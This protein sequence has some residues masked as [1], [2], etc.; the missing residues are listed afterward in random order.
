MYAY[1]CTSWENI[2]KECAQILLQVSKN[3]SYSCG[4]QC[5]FSFL[6][7]FTETHCKYVYL[8]GLIILDLCNR[9]W[10]PNNATL[11]SYI[12]LFA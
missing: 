8:H 12:T 7:Y 6:I 9:V 3:Y 5:M 10:I 1:A 2:A 11:I 4:G